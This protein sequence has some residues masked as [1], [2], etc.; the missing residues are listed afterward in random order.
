MGAQ[1]EYVV[2]VNHP[3]NKAVGHI[4]TCGAVELWGGGRRSTGEWLGPYQT[5]AEAELRG[6]QS[7]KP[8]HWCRL[9][10]R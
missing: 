10:C 2:Y 3:H 5:K 7:G 8:F 9:C 6:K 4:K 1:I